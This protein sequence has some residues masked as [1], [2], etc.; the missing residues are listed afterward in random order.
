MWQDTQGFVPQYLQ[1][2][3]DC[4]DMH[5]QGMGCSLVGRPS[6]VHACD[7]LLV[8]AEQLHTGP[9]FLRASVPAPMAHSKGI[10]LL[11]ACTMQ[12]VKIAWTTVGDS[13]DPW[14]S[15]VPPVMTHAV[16]G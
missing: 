11:V 5:G 1:T 16:E 14:R 8:V 12:P 6:G 10:V 15:P 7:A 9:I 2:A 4:S 13:C 3:A